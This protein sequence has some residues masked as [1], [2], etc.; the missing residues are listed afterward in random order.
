MF[1]IQ[2]PNYTDHEAPPF[3]SPHLVSLL[4]SHLMRCHLASIGLNVNFTIH[5]CTHTDL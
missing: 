5:M 4:Y 2:T 1:E 3:M